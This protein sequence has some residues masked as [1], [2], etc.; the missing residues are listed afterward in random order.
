[1]EVDVEPLAVGFL[2][3]SL[4]FVDVGLELVP[5]PLRLGISLGCF[6]DLPVRVQLDPVKAG[7]DDVGVVPRLVLDASRIWRANS[8]VFRSC[9]VV[10]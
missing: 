6:D 4:G 10:P 9:T 7:D 2:D 1:M 5:G 3:D 8:C